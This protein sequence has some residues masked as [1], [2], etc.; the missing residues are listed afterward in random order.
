MTI[1]IVKAKEKYMEECKSALQNSEL[2]R[3]YFSQENKAMEAIKEGIRKDE[4]LVALNDEDEFMGFLWYILNGAFH[5]FPYLHI[6]AVNEKYRSKGIGSYLLEYFEKEV[7]KNQTKIF[8]VVADF[9][10]R[11]KQLYEKVGYKEV[12]VLPSLYKSG[13][14]EYLMMKEIG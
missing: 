14:T 11:A 6:I 13:V 1:Q 9:N 2:G 5:S 3:V 7:I 4:M 12:G 10:P 8:L